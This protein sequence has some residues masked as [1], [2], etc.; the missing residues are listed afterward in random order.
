MSAACDAFGGSPA[1]YVARFLHRRC[2][3]PIDFVISND[4]LVRRGSDHL[5]PGP[6]HWRKHHRLFAFVAQGC[7]FLAFTNDCDHNWKIL[8]GHFGRGNHQTTPATVVNAR[9]QSRDINSAVALPF[10]MGHSLF[11]LG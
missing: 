1:L 10:I 9:T 8:L 3:T 7:I 5:L 11:M 2:T 4:G 6:R